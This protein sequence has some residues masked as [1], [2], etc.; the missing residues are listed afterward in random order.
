[1]KNALVL[2]A[3]SIAAPA[4][5]V[6]TTSRDVG[7]VAADGSVYLGWHLLKNTN[8]TETYEV[9][10]QLGGFSTVRLH[11]E[12]PLALGQVL[13]IF[14]DGE[15]WVAPAPAALGQEEWS[16]PIPLPGGPRAIHSVVVQ[17]RATTSQLAK[18]EIHGGR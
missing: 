10:S 2:L 1:M 8:D 12:K 15:R 18:L 16:S 7:S 14:A 13:V 3:L 5:V 9:G 17:G 4:C 6:T 11:A